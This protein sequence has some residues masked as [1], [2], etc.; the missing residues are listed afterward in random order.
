ML[1]EPSFVMEWDSNNNNNNNNNNNKIIIWINNNNDNDSNKKNNLIIAI[2]PC[3]IDF[4]FSVTHTHAK[5]LC[6][7]NL[8]IQQLA[9]WSLLYVAIGEKR[10]LFIFWF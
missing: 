7:L 8:F 1:L 9:C 3:Q 5:K 2:M 10:A 4:L 6:A